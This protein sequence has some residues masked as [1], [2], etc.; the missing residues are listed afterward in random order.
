LATGIFFKS[1]PVNLKIPRSVFY[2]FAAWFIYLIF[3]FLIQAQDWVSWLPM[4]SLYLAGLICFLVFINLEQTQTDF[5][6]DQIIWIAVAQALWIL[7][8]KWG[9][10]VVPFQ[11][12]FG[13]AEFAATW[14]GVAAIVLFQKL[15]KKN[16]PRLNFFWAMNLGLLILA[17]LLLHN[18]GTLIF[19]VLLGVWQKFKISKWV[20]IAA[21]PVFVAAFL[22]SIKTRM[23]LWLVAVFEMLRYPWGVSPNKTILNTDR[24]RRARKAEFTIWQLSCGWPLVLPDSGI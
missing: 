22:F 6:W 19:L 20:W 7:V 11:T 4:A 14:I 9:G 16:P 23:I 17:A 2:F 1:S 3:H 8:Y 13:N 24:W 15:E 18:K 5:L 12:F 21:A 10:G